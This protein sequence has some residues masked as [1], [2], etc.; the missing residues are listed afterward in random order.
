MTW[1]KIPG[2]P[3]YILSSGGHVKNS[4]TGRIM[5]PKQRFDGYLEVGLIDSN[6]QLKSKK[7]HKLMGDIF[8]TKPTVNGN[9]IV[10]HKN[11]ERT[12]NSE[13]NLEWIT[14]GENNTKENQT[15]KKTEYQNNTKERTFSS[16]AYNG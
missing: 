6:G 4:K 11:N 14:K 9:Y 8:L 12:D 16:K 7:I 5:K 15:D 3:S 13:G 10:N 1:K 2:F